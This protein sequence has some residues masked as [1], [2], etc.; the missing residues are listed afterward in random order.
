MIHP[1]V[2]SKLSAHYSTILDWMCQSYV[3]GILTPAQT[4][5]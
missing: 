2:N 5:S 3:E 1:V 4:Q